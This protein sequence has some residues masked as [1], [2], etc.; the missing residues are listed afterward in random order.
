MV[1]FCDAPDANVVI[2]EAPELGH[3]TVPKGS[4]TE[5]AFN[6]VLPVLVTAMV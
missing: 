5:M 4:V 1:Q 3:V 2:V 6:V